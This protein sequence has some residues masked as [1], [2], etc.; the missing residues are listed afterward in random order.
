MIPCPLLPASPSSASR[1]SDTIGLIRYILM[2]ADPNPQCVR[3][4]HRV[5]NTKYVWQQSRHPGPRYRLCLL[6]RG[7][8]LFASRSLPERPS[9]AGSFPTI[10]CSAT[11]RQSRR[12]RRPLRNRYSGRRLPSGPWNAACVPSESQE[13][14][15]RCQIIIVR[16]LRL[17]TRIIDDIREAAKYQPVWSMARP[18][19]YQRI[20]NTSFGGNK[21]HLWQKRRNSNILCRTFL[22]LAGCFLPMVFCNT[23][24]RSPTSRNR[25]SSL[26][27]Y[28]RRG[29][30]LVQNLDVSLFLFL[31]VF[32]A[33]S[34]GFI[35][36]Y[37]CDK[38]RCVDKREER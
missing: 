6:C 10:S 19:T 9:V 17:I 25:Q 5:S 4:Q 8:R 31:L 32:V 13:V 2:V 11:K 20:R 29:L 23:R 7:P 37:W 27:L 3:L 35:Y 14:Q 15:D 36:R 24:P 21:S 18:L 34:G 16:G 30:W 26:V 33:L 12:R 1:L 28:S 38:V 22:D